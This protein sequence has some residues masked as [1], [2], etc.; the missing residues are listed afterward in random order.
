MQIYILSSSER[1]RKKD[2]ECFK[3]LLLPRLFKYLYLKLNLPFSR[4]MARRSFENTCKIGLIMFHGRVLGR[5]SVVCYILAS[6][7]ISVLRVQICGFR[8][9]GFELFVTSL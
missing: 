2:E 8:L 4:S 9:F 3:C 7:N 6:L 5:I 1:E